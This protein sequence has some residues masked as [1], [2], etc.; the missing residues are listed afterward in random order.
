MATYLK[1]EISEWNTS[2]L[3]RWLIDNKYPGISELCQALKIILLMKVIADYARKTMIEMLPMR[4]LVKVLLVS[5]ISGVL[6]FSV[7]SLIDANK[8]VLLG[9]SFVL[10]IILFYSICWVLKLSYKDVVCGFVRK[11]KT[12]KVLRFVP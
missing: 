5:L 6:S 12:E 1:R 3:S 11:E 8:F 9:V 7:L 10:F 2:D 4:D